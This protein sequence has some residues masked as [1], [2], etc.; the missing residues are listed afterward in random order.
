MRP[1]RWLGKKKD[2]RKESS[3]SSDSSSSDDDQESSGSAS[4]AK[5][6]TSE[7]KPEPVKAKPKCEQPRMVSKQ[8]EPDNKEKAEKK[9]KTKAAKAVTPVGGE[10]FPDTTDSLNSMAMFF[11]AHAAVLR[12]FGGRR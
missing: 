3:S 8:S 11:E 10:T 5:G 1:R 9:K 6:T 2:A 7:K 4:A 12:S